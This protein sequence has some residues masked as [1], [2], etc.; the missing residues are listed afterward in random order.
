MILTRAI[1]LAVGLPAAI[2]AQNL[3]ISVDDARPL[4]KAIR[5][6]AELRGWQISYE[7]PQYSGSDLVDRTIVKR[8]GAQAFLPRG[9]RIDLDLTG[10]ES[11]QA[12]LQLLIHE[13][14]PRNNPGL[15]RVQTVGSMLV[16]TPAHG[17][18]LDSLVSLPGKDR[19]LDEF[20]RDIAEILTRVGPVPV[21]GPGMLVGPAQRFSFACDNEP[22]RNVLARVLESVTA[23]GSR[24]PLYVWDLLY[25]PNYGYVLNVHSVKQMIR[26]P[27]GGSKLIDLR[28]RGSSRP[29]Q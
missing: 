26:V 16:V 28:S 25:A 27:D 14:T 24:H 15:F 2:S 8:G 5:T 21:H 13:N 6:L 20:L 19:T 17:S 18:P 29:R 7:D 12:A 4:W 11:P 3:R 9:G 23:A 1:V 10:A 22:A